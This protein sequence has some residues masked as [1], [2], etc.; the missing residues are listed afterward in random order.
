MRITLKWNSAHG[1]RNGINAPPNNL[2]SKLAPPS[3]RQKI[4]AKVI[5]YGLL[6]SRKSWS[7]GTQSPPHQSRRN[8]HWLR[9]LGDYALS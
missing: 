3:F 7:C 6:W 1:L 9:N 8:K 2:N 5:A 4:R